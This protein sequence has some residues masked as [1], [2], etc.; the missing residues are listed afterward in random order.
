MTF[1][2]SLFT[3]R[4]QRCRPKTLTF[5]ILRWI[6]G[7]SLCIMT[8]FLIFFQSTASI[9]LMTVISFERYIILVRP[10]ISKPNF[11]SSFRNLLS[12]VLLAFLVTIPPAL[13]WSHYTQDDLKVACNVDWKGKTFNIISYNI[14]IMFV[15]FF[16][17]IGLILYFNVKAY[18]K[19]LIACGMSVP[20]S[21][22]K[23]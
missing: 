3:S 7:Q 16:I 9:Y 22:T 13:G 8:G 12:C 1:N 14:F 18:N 4:L 15:I 19:V 23:K 10:F 17:P 6:F 21:H 11:K 2:F 20:V 5:L